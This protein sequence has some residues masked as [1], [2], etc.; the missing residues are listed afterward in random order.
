MKK[1]I[2]TAV[3]A[4]ALAVG[5]TASAQDFGG[6]I[7][8]ILGFGQPTYNQQ[9]GWGNQQYGYGNQQ[10]GYGNQQY[11]YGNQGYGNQ[12]YSYGGPAVVAPQT[13]I[14]QDQY[15]RQFYYDQYGR[16]VYSQAQTQQQRIVGYDQWGR[17]V[18]G[19]SGSYAY[20]GSTWGSNRDRDGDGVADSQDRYPD[21]RRYY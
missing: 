21:D 11:G 18:Y 17:P 7:A 8:S 10:Y 14:Y 2:A 16:Q 1:L 5:G 4:G 15:G 9:Y 13:Q 19:N 3:A 6:V 12:G 20:G